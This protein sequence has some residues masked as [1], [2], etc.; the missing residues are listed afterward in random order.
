[1]YAGEYDPTP[2]R[3]PKTKPPMDV[4]L[5]CGHTVKATPYWSSDP[6]YGGWKPPAYA[7]CEA[8]RSTVG[9]RRRVHPS[10]SRTSPGQGAGA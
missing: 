10:E 1:M 4:L 7:W 5:D 6:L 2:V 9:V 8:D 3:E